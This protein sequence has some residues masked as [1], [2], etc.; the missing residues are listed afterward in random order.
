MQTQADAGLLTRAFDRSCW[1]QLRFL[2]IEVQHEMLRGGHYTRT[3]V[4]SVIGA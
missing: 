2:S 3:C 1:W 4:V